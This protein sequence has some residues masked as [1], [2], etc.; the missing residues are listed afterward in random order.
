MT[1]EG[2]SHTCY[3]LPLSSL[4]AQGTPLCRSPAILASAIVSLWLSLAAEAALG[5]TPV[6]ER[7]IL[8]LD[9]GFSG[10]GNAV[11]QLAPLVAAMAGGQT[12][13]DMLTAIVLKAF[14]GIHYVRERWLR[15]ELKGCSHRLYLPCSLSLYN[16]LV[17]L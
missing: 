4:T 12:S 2:L 1:S 10:E 14:E 15:I 7:A 3:C 16:T 8:K 13:R 5:R 6:P 17:V 9:D 11:V